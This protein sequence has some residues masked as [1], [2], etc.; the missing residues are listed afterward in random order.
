MAARTE[1]SDRKP[2][3]RPSRNRRRRREIGLAA[4][5]REL[6]RAIAAAA[7][8][9][10]GEMFGHRLDQARPFRLELTVDVEPGDRWH[11][12]EGDDLEEQIR[13][14]VQNMAVRA[15]A[16]RA[17]R[18][19]CYRCESPDCEHALPPRTGCVFGGYSS[20]GL[21]QWP[22]LPQALLDIGHPHV[23]RL[24]AMG[25]RELVAAYIDGTTLKRRQLNVFGKSSK[26]YDILGQLIFGYVHLKSGGTDNPNME[27]IAITLQA[28]EVRRPDGTPRLEL[29][30]LG[31][32]DD[33]T[34][35]M[36]AFQGPFQL[37]IL[38]LIVDARR[39][40]TAL[41]PRQHSRGKHPPRLRSDAP[42]AV[43]DILTDMVRRLEH[44]GRQRRRRTLHAEER[45][46][47]N[48]PTAKAVEDAA[49]APDDHLF[50][51]EKRNSVIVVGP[52]KRI[53]VFS[54]EGRLITTLLLEPEVVRGRI[55]RHRWQ[56]L[57]PDR[58]ERFNAAVGRG[59][60]T[61]LTS[62]ASEISPSS[63]R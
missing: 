44:L 53:H 25:S 14:A 24:F 23:D 18:V 57:D 5:V 1:G 58:L 21:P 28:V 37:R 52:R 56:L 11:L 40:I 8:E 30:V 31:R 27:R 61:P 49:G 36:D 7:W 42:F 22:E 47:G 55:R 20:T 29:N 54:L 48:R 2:A 43:S 32:L 59:G 46:E 12:A 62:A 19:Y 38:D 13:I 15:G 63:D 6:R 34:S 3:G 50:W 39:R 17:G 33:G 41:S 26:T 10:Y 51:D 45:R 16:Y 9:A 4:R 60:T 35:V